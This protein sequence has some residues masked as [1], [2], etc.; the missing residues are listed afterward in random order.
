[1]LSKCSVTLH[2]LLRCNTDLY[3]TTQIYP[4]QHKL[5]LCNTD[6]HEATKI[7]TKQRRFILCDT[8]LYS[9][10]KICGLPFDAVLVGPPAEPSAAKTAANPKMEEIFEAN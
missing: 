2:V 3:D 9:A 10:K 1:M 8:D 5:M 7:Y 4:K 6:L